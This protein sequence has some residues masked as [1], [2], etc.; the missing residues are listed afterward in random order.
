MIPFQW[1]LVF[2]LRA[3][4]S[5]LHWYKAPLLKNFLSPARGHPPPSS[6]LVLAMSAS[7]SSVVR[8]LQSPLSHTELYG[9]EH[10]LVARRESKRTTKKGRRA[11]SCGATSLPRKTA[12]GKSARG[13]RQGER[14]SKS[15]RTVSVTRICSGTGKK[16]HSLSTSVSSGKSNEVASDSAAKHS[17]KGGGPRAVISAPPGRNKDEVAIL[18]VESTH[19]MS[20]QTHSNYHSDTTSCPLPPVEANSPHITKKTVNKCSISSSSSSSSSKNRQSWWNERRVRGA[21]ISEN[22]SVIKAVSGRTSKQPEKD[23]ASKSDLSVPS[24]TESVLTTSTTSHSLNSGRQRVAGPVVSSRWSKSTPT[25]PS[26]HPLPSPGVPRCVAAL[27]TAA[28]DGRGWSRGGRRQLELRD[29]AI[30][31]GTTSYKHIIVMSG[32]GVSTPSGIPDFRYIL[33]LCFLDRV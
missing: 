25:Q 1:K 15:V 20:S 31:L 32:A 6:G 3:L 21:W 30:G 16:E 4:T 7:S 19:S 14:R 17:V 28:A 29:I 27:T 10:P 26:R 12:S 2:L 22:D 24:E 8:V 33:H 18:S 9:T 13:S 5:N 23:R 11:R